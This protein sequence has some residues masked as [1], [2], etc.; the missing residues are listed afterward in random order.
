VRSD[1]DV[2]RRGTLTVASGGRRLETR[3]VPLPDS[4]SLTSQI[5]LPAARLPAGWS[6][7]DVRIA[8]S[9]DAEPRDDERRVA[10]QV[11]AQPTAVILAAPPGWEAR[12]FARALAEVARVPVQ[13]FDETEPGRW[14]D[15]TTLSPVSAD[16]LRRAV[17]GARMV[18]LIGDPRR[19]GSFGRRPGVIVWSLGEGRAGDWYVDVPPGSPLAGGLAGIMW[20]S[21]PPAT[22]L[23][24]IPADSAGVV[25]L[26]AR[27]ARRGVPRPL[28]V[29]H[30]SADGRRVTIAGAGLWR[31]GFRGGA[32]AEAYRSL[33]AALADWL[34][35]SAVPGADRVEPVATEAANGLPLVWRWRA[36]A[37][38]RTLPIVLDGAHGVKTDM[39]RF[40][41][42]GQAELRLPPGAYRWRLPDGREQ[43]LVIVEEYSDEWRP[44]APTL[45]AQTG[46]SGA[47][48]VETSARDRWWWY[49]VAVAAF[50]GE[51][52]WRRRRGLP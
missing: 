27:L 10:V 28:A 2:P 37:A 21:L 39:L 33:V 45:A 29:L 5:L 3:D 12:F 1:R 13:S 48:L 50:A 8:A 19:L 52:A 34:L 4:G 9:G 47:R 38:P 6:A 16:G 41:A 43:G 46:A 36:R 40:D 25:L 18:A 26:T 23:V 44:A 20:D 35:G 17:A 15:G 22:A 11:S 14:R 32:S 24:D 30:D 49:W 7:I 42:L 31:W 51:W